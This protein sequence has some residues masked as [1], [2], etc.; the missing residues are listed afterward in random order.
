V[1]F[2]PTIHSPQEVKLAPGWLTDLRRRAYDGSRDG[3]D[4]E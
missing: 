3:R 1:V 2:D 4:G